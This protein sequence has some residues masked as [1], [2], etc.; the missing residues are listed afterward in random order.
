MKKTA[1]ILIIAVTIFASCSK[2]LNQAPISSATTATF[3]QQ[4]SDFLQA[5]NATYNS[6]R[7][8]PDRLMFLSEIRSDNIYPTN[9]VARDPDP[10]NNFASNIPANT[11]VEEGWSADFAGIFKANTV[12][13]QIKQNSAAIGSAALATRLTAEARFLRA[14]FYFDMIRYYGKLPIIDHAATADE[15]SKIGRSSI[16]D[17]YAFIIADLQFAVA[18]LPLNFSGTFPAYGATD[19]GRATK[20]AAEAILAQVYMARSGPTYGIEG[21]GL[22]LSEWSLALPL[23]QDIISSGL[24]AFN[25]TPYAF[26]VPAAGIFSYS[27]QSPVTNKEA[28]FDVMFITGQSPVL[29]TDFTWQLVSQSYF[30]SLPAGNTPANGA[31]GVPSASQDLLKAY[32]TAPLDTR[33]APTLHTSAYT[34]SGIADA[35]PFI[36]KYLDTTKIPTSRFDWGINFIAVRYTDVLLLKAECVLNGAPGSQ[37]TDVDAVVNQVRARAGQTA[38]TNVTKAQLL[39]ERRREFAGEGSRWFDLQRS[40]NLITIMNAWEATEDAIKKKMNPVVANYIIYPVP[41]TQLDAAPGLYTQN[42]GY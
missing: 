28:I 21:P 33:K 42:P 1:Y 31:L 36:R 4:P 8:Y 22:G 40:G 9:D 29:G 18:N 11:Y 3:Y 27:N 25:A 16:S 32:S 12:L 20:Y 14:F 34:Y 35:N 41:Q 17:V 5:V 6:L 13:D 38:L 19:V 23:L 37:T 15:V 24:F 26:P 39:D 2:D 30:N 7:G 10:V